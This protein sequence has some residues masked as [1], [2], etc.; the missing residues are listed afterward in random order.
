MEGEREEVNEEAQAGSDQEEVGEQLIPSVSVPIRMVK[1]EVRKQTSG[2]K[3]VRVQM[4]KAGEGNGILKQVMI[5]HDTRIKR[6]GEEGGGSEAKFT[7]EEVWEDVRY[8]G[9]CRL[10][11]AYLEDV[12]ELEEVMPIMLNIEK[13]LW[14]P[15][16]RM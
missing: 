6:E 9:R 11:T 8:R 5:C 15:E 12:P 10:R 1:K 2:S 13:Q 14:E 3:E 4:E 7:L 16:Q